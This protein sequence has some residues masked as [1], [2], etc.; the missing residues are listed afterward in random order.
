MTNRI[1]TIVFDFDYTLADSSRGAIDCINFALGQMDLPAAPGDLV[2]R[3]IGLSLKDTF[4]ALTGDRNPARVSRFSEFFIERAEQTMVEL[5]VLFPQVPAAV[6]DLK[7]T[8][9]S[10]AIVSTKYRRR[11]RSILSREALL[12]PF[13][14][15]VG[16]EDVTEHK[17][18]PEGVFK[19]LSAL[20]ASPSN[21]IYIGDSVVDAQV[22]ERAGMPFIAVLSGVTLKG[23]FDRFP[24]VEIIDTIEDLPGVIAGLSDGTIAGNIEG[25]AAG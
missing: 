22:A 8:G 4:A 7:R 20:S 2:C 18:H 3:T 10:L 13:D 5:T 6:R 9:Y 25:R 17:P 24:V 23:A 16:G 15:I 19:A 14:V 11:I 12:D 21:S 1:Q